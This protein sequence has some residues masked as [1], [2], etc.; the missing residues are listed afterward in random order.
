VVEPLAEAFGEYLTRAL[1]ALAREAPVHFAAM[2]AALDGRAALVRIGS[3]APVRVCLAGAPPWVTSGS[4]GRV[5]VSL[6]PS[7]LGAFL[8]GE[9]TIEEGLDADRVAIRGALEDVAG[10]LDG[11]ACWLHGA[12]R[13]P[14]LASLHAEYLAL[15]QRGVGEGASAASSQTRKDRHP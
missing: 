2:S 11:L 7:D 9:L 8:R 14:P 6:S 4:D 15:G 12:L 13:C 5:E 10:F 3:A 1:A